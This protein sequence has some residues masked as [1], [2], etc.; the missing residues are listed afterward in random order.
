MK[1][2][3]QTGS[4]DFSGSV[5]QH[6]DEYLGPLFFEPYAIEVAKRIDTSGSCLALELA[7]GTG[8]V[9]RHLRNVL[10]LSS[11]LIASDISEDMLKIA[12]EK[13]KDAN[14][15]WQVIDAQDLPFENS[16][17]DLIVC[18]F[19]YMFVPDKGKAFAETHRILRPGGMLIFTTWD[20]L[21]FNA[22]SFVYRTLAKKYLEEPLP[23]MYNLPF[24]MSEETEID[25]QLEKAGFKKINIEKSEKLSVSQSAQQAAEGLTQGGLIYNE[26]MKRN[27]EWLKE[28]RSSLEKQLAEKFG[29]S[30]MIAPMSALIVQA[31]K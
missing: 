21:E 3:E 20:K 4:F 17:V 29:D 12:K 15:E 25:E 14:I 28:I 19:G 6:Y 11:K 30:P 9:T 27:P 26:I 24:S 18:C 13:L 22:A 1:T 31:W 23:A 2:T 10:P 8:R 5:P 7:S 16:S